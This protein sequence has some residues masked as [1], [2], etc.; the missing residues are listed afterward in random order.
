MPPTNEIRESCKDDTQVSVVVGEAAHLTHIIARILDLPLR[1]VIHLMGSVS[2]IQ[3]TNKLPYDYSEGNKKDTN[4]PAFGEFPLYVRGSNANE[5]SKFEYALYLLNKNVAQLR[6]Q[7]GLI[8]VDLRPTLQNLQEI[9]GLG[10]DHVSKDLERNNH[11]ISTIEP[12]NRD[13]IRISFSH[14]ENCNSKSYLN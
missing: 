9:L 14:F 8:T 2:T 12:Q 1:H 6:W 13:K 11:K 10:K 4:V 7:C 3:D 5:W